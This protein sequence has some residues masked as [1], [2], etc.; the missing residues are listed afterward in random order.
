MIDFTSHRSP[1]IIG[2][3]FRDPPI[4]VGALM[5]IEGEKMKMNEER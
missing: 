4:V 1:S 3:H 2:D 5:T